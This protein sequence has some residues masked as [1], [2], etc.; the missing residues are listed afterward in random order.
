[1]KTFVFKIENGKSDFID[2]KDK[3][4]YRRLILLL[5][6]KGI[7]KFKIVVE[8]LDDY[9]NLSESQ[10]NLFMVLVSKISEF[11]GNDRGTVRTTLEKNLIGNNKRVEDLSK[12]E[13]SDFIEEAIVFS[14]EFFDMNI[15]FNPETNYIEIDKI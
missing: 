7:K 14:N 12:S 8:T 1:M 10:L 9:G 6:S 3:A 15:S 4:A 13:F 5:E 2:S 11:S